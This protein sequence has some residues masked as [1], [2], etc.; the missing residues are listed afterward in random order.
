MVKISQ[1][2]NPLILN[3]EWVNF[4]G[5]SEFKSEDGEWKMGAWS[6]IAIIDD[7]SK[8]AEIEEKYSGWH[9]DDDFPE[10]AVFNQDKNIPVYNS[11]GQLCVVQFHYRGDLD[12]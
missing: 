8:V 11:K 5:D 3:A 9:L 12:D 4:Q 6:F 10:D 7:E 1:L 2:L